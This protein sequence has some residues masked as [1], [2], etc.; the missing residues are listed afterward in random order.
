[1]VWTLLVDSIGTPFSSFTYEDANFVKKTKQSDQISFFAV[2]LPSW[3]E[4]REGFF[5]AV[6][7]PQ[8][9]GKHRD[10]TRLIHDLGIKPKK[11][12][13]EAFHTHWI[14]SD[15]GVLSLVYSPIQLHTLLLFPIFGEKKEGGGACLFFAL[16]M[17][18]PSPSPTSIV[19]NKLPN[20]E[21]AMGI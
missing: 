4:G 6:H 15:G 20:L 12:W 2:Q 10:W 1:M 14:G 3:K 8:L 13:S 5:F 21:S 16:P 17:D 9:L 11:A 18:H 19:G 7:G